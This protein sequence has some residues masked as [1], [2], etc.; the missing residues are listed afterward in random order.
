[1]TEHTNSNRNNR[2]KRCTN[3]SKNLQIGENNENN[4]NLSENTNDIS[5]LKTINNNKDKD[6]DNKKRK[7]KQRKDSD[8]SSDYNNTSIFVKILKKI[9]SAQTNMNKV[10]EEGLKAK[11]LK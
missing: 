11:L 8:I 6:R 1:M 4:E 9:K 10:K 3:C 7:L 2:N 5:K